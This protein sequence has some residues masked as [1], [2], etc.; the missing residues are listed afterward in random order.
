M[1]DI[2][3]PHHAATTRRDFFI[4]LTTVVLGILIAIGLEQ[5][6]EYLHHRHLA[7][8]AT[9]ALLEERHSDEVANDFN[10]FGTERHE[11]ELLHDLAVLRALR[12]HQPLPPGPFI[13]RHVNYIYA[14][15]EWRK[16]HQSGT[17]N[18]LTGN[19]GFINYRYEMQDSFEDLLTHSNQDL[20]RAASVLRSPTDPLN[21]F[22]KNLAF[23]R[24]F[25]RLVAAHESLPQQEIDAAWA[26]LAEPS[27]LAALSP[28]QTDSLER[29]LQ[30]ALADDESMLSD[31]FHIKR[32]LANHPAQ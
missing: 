20:S 22:E 3:P 9:R 26:T 24:F 18:Y 27:H 29:G 8:E 31:C 15:E 6:V 28:A 4:H 17:I 30:I 19:I 13:V 7:N 2:H 16:I 21:S 12:A 10:I 23:S 32:N 25:N 11:H 1:I 14:T 5:T